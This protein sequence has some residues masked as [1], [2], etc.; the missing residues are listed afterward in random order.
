MERNYIT[1]PSGIRYI[2]DWS[3]MNGGYSLGQYPFPHILNKQVTGCGF[4][5]YCITS[6]MD[7]ILCSPRKVLLENKESQHQNEVFYVNMDESSVGYD[8][9][10]IVELPKVQVPRL[11]IFDKPEQED[12][13]LATIMLN[14]RSNLRTNLYN[15]INQRKVFNLPVKILVTYD[16]FG[17]VKE[18]IESMP[19]LVRVQ[20]FQVVIDEFQSVLIDSRFKSSTEMEFLGHLQGLQKV[21]FVSATPMLDPYLELLDDFR[22]LPYFEL[23]WITEDPGRVKK[24]VL[25]VHPSNSLVADATKIITRYQKGLFEDWSYRTETGRIERI[26]SKE[27]V[28]YF[29]SVK[30]ICEIIKKCKLTPDDT[31]VLCSRSK[32]NE[33]AVKKAFKAACKRKDGGI[34]S[35]PKKDE[36]HKM[37]T[38]CTRTVYLGADFYSTNARSFIFSD[39]NID[40]LAVDISMDLPQILGRQRLDANPWKDTAEFYFKATSDSRLVDPQ[41]YQD[42]VKSKLENSNDLLDTMSQIISENERKNAAQILCNKIKV[43]IDVEHYKTDYV[44]INRSSTGEFVPVINNLVIVAEQRAF[45]IQQYDYKDRF[46]VF[47]RLSEVSSVEKNNSSTDIYKALEDFNAL[48]HFSDKL[49]LAC[50]VMEVLG[51]NDKQVFLENLPMLYRNVYNIIGPEFC[52][53]YSYR[54]GLI[55]GEYDKMMVN[56]D[57]DVRTRILDR[58]QVGQKY[59]VAD[60]RDY[61]TNLYD[62]LGYNGIPRSTVLNDY[63][64]VQETSIHVEG[65]KFR[66]FRILSV[67]E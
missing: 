60:I 44:A 51:T 66:A 55:M 27:A 20:D 46:T 19:E 56:Q 54:K 29:N 6:D 49:R 48:N 21:C 64:E 42:K 15:Y 18:F 62:Q 45:D 12:P 10:T 36:P 63:F 13:N 5:E 52:K 2:S 14:R 35:V 57:I 30:T 22:G 32:E 53:K 41:V 33:A 25:F 8:G 23:D 37:F 67:K 4:T 24:P 26:Y 47:N 40:C 61:I 38:L 1:V 58:F 34:G 65:R 7:V 39:P 16:S 50:E 28:L 43:T 31:N 11:T 9:E 3:K 17:L 59:T